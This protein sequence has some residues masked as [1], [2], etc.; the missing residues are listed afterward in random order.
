MAMAMFSVDKENSHNARTVS[1]S[2]NDAEMCLMTPPR[3]PLSGTCQWTPTAN[4][5]LLLKAV[6]PDLHN[7][8]VLHSQNSVH[9]VSTSKSCLK[10]PEVTLANDYVMHFSADMMTTEKCAENAKVS[11]D[12]RTRK[13][14]SLG[15]ICER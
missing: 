4:L 12:K 2:L 10:V 13:D 7:R 15:L 6:S 14:K 5:K 1:F 9:G 3:Q 8:D 11:V